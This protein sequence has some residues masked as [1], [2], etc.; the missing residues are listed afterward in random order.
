MDLDKFTG[1]IIDLIQFDDDIIKKESQDIF[2]SMKNRIKDFIEFSKGSGDMKTF[3]EENRVIYGRKFSYEDAKIGMML[4]DEDKK[5]LKL[6]KDGQLVKA[7]RIYLNQYQNDKAKDKS[8]QK[9]RQC[10]TKDSIIILNKKFGKIKDLYKEKYRGEILNWDGEKNTLSKVKDIWKSGKKEIYRIILKN[11]LYLDC[12]AL[13]RIWEDNLKK[14]VYAK[15]LKIGNFLKIY[16]EFKIYKKIHINLIGQEIL[17]NNQIVCIKKIGEKETYDLSLENINSPYFY[18]N[19]ILVHN[20]ELTENEINE[21]I[22]LSVSRPYTNVRHIFPTAGMAQK[23]SKEKISVAI[24]KSPNLAIHLKRPYNLLSKAFKNGSFYTIDSSWTDYQGRGPSSDK[25]TFDEYESQNPQI[26]DIFSE[27]TSHSE[28]GKKTRI[29]TP[30]FPNS[31]IDLMFQKGCGY[32]WHIT[33]PNPKCKKEQILEFPDNIINFFE[34]GGGISTVSENYLKKLNKVYLGCKFCGAYIDRTTQVYIKNS[35]WIP[36]RPHL[37]HDRASYRITYMMLPWKTGKEILYKYHTFRFVHQFWNE[38]MGYAYLDKESQI[39]R[40]IFEQCID[41]SF[42]NTYQRL[43]NAKNVSVGIDWG[44]VSWVTVVANNFLPEQKN[45]KVIYVEKIDDESLKKNG[46]SAAQQ[47]DHVK[48]TCDIIK[49]FKARIVVNDANGIGVD[50]NSYLVRKFPTRAYGCFYDTDERKKQKA[51]KNLIKPMWNEGQKTVTV[52]RVG[53]F[54]NL[55]Q[56]FEEK[57]LKI[58]KLDPSIEE[59]IQHLANLVVE[60]YEDEN[61]GALYEVIGKTGPDHLGHATNLALIGF[62]KIVNIDR[63]NSGSGIITNPNKINE[64]ILK[65]LK[66]VQQP[67]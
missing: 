52:S 22:Y 23:I 54:K 38:I 10:I 64:D 56:R 41:P 20:S 30:V 49:F 2:F 62:E 66:K 59:F 17:K 21:N 37:I 43:G 48:R 25:L 42:V 34:I 6:N 3:V 26:E 67:Y 58:P 33:C 50:R 13:E 65:Q 29:S 11:G 8:C 63:E 27:S 1:N 4:G 55:L 12:S 31:G 18:V 44:T 46:Y 5:N 15:N 40:E 51:K 9:C 14:I 61:T 24:E 45:P 16:K 57:Q 19:G 47:T 36:E 39:T 60:R 53:S 35:R 7:P 32:T 28:L